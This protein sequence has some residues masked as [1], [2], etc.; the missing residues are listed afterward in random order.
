MA[1]AKTDLSREVG[2]STLVKHKKL[3]KLILNLTV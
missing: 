3:I 1:T 2:Q